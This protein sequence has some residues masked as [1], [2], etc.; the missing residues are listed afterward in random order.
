MDPWIIFALVSCLLSAAL[1]YVML[2]VK[3]Y[4]E[5]QKLQDQ[6]LLAQADAAAVKKKLAGFTSYPKHLNA[7]AQHL[8]KSLSPP[9]VKVTRELVLVHTVP[10]DSL[11]L[12]ADATV[13]IKYSAQFGYSIELTP[14]AL[15]VL[16][17]SSGVSVKIPRPMLHGEPT[18]KPSAP[19]IFSSSEPNDRT[20]LINAANGQLKAQAQAQGMAISTEEA[21][22]SACRLRV[23]ELVRDFLGQQAGV[24]QPPA[25]WVDFK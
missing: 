8:T 25:V 12:K 4:G 9:V 17:T 2:Q 14:G 18:L 6:L 1:V 16:E 22:R 5:T 7:V 3:H 23:L 10:K 11:K 21:V 13:V 19:Q 24:S 15:E 20:A